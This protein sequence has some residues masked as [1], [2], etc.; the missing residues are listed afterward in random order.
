MKKLVG[1]LDLS[2]IYAFLGEATLGLT[3]LFYIIIARVLGPEQY[4]V[5]TAAVALG[6]ILSLFIQF[7]LPSLLGRDVAASPQVAPKFTLTFLLLQA[8]NSFVILLVLFPLTQMLGFSGIGILICYL[9]VLA[10]I[11]RSAKL[12]LRNVLRGINEFGTETISVSIERFFA[13]GLACVVLFLTQSIV[14]VMIT[15]ISIRATDALGLLY[16]INRKTRVHNAISLGSLAGTWRKAYPFALSGILWIL[17]YQVDILTLQWLAPATEVGFYGAAYRILEIFAALPRVI[18]SVTIFKFASFYLQEPSRLSEE[19]YRATRLLLIGVLPVLIGISLFVSVLI[20]LLY[21]DSF[22]PAAEAL[23]ILLP[24]LGIKLFGNLAQNFL[25]ATG[26]E[27]QLPPLLLAT[28]VVNIIANIV[29][30]PSMGAVGAA[31]ATL[32][33]EVVLAIAGLTL[34]IRLGYKTIGQQLQKVALLSLLAVSVPSFIR[35][36]LNPWLGITL[37]LVSLSI[38]AVLMRKK[39]FLD[40]PC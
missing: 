7:G 13:Y 18:M 36:G 11:C 29:L 35:I 23:S 2:Y 5:F 17:Y 16:Y 32:L 34:L 20:S 33:S 4:G 12:T 19:L 38:I 37:T 15:V 22:L 31:I 27:K 8:I 26:R 9:A 21:G 25:S 39:T 6:A 10:E 1:R 3:F 40:T 30:V 24:S 14:W 28:V